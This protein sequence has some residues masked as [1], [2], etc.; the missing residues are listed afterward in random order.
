[1]EVIGI[2][3]LAIICQNLQESIN[4]YCKGLGFE[5]IYQETNR[6]DK[7]STQVLLMTKSGNGIML[8]GP[9]DP[10]M[11]LAEKNIGVGSMQYLTLYVTNI[12]LDKAFYTLSNVGI[13]ISEEIERGYERM[14]F[15]EDPN[16]TLITLTSWPDISS[17]NTNQNRDTLK[18]AVT[19]K[20]KS[21]SEYL[22]KI[23]FKK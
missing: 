1:M 14:V 10:K 8:I 21:I 2:G 15:L 4:F 17:A 22:E 13:Q 3:Y 20:S 9:N 18:R 16:G 12:E 7:E 23:H 6:D 5:E 19:N 11:K